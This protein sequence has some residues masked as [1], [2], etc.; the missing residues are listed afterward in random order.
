MQDTNQNKP[1]QTQSQAHF[2]TR[3]AEPKNEKR[4]QFSKGKNEHKL[5]FNKGL[6]K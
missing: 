2:Q 6:R 5:S 1:N 4:N 3:D